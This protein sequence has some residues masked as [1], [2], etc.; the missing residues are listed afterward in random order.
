MLIFCHSG[1]SL[2]PARCW[3]AIMAT[4]DFILVDH[5]GLRGTGASS[6]SSNFHSS[7][8]LGFLNIVA[9]RFWTQGDDFDSETL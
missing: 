7:P 1:S 5:L 4:V 9:S 2:L 6:V 3:R 8:P